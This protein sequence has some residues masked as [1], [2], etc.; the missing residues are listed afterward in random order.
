MS[1]ARAGPDPESVA[2]DLRRW[3][4]SEDLIERW[5]AQHPSRNEI[6]VLACHREIVE[7]YQ[8]C[9]LSYV[10]TMGGPIC[11]GLSM[12]EIQAALRCTGVPR[13]RWPETTQAL[14]IMGRAAAH[15][16]NRAAAARAST[17]R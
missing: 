8:C 17:R 5:H 10:S 7:V 2:E 15:A 9:Q 13:S 11:L 4:V 16:I 6:E 3:G 1:G 14:V 12:T